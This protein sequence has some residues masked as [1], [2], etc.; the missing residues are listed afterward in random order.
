MIR[1]NKLVLLLTVLSSHWAISQHTFSPYSVYGI[2]DLQDKSMSHQFAMGDVGIAAPSYYH[3][4]SSNPALL[5][6]NLLTTFEL[7]LQG[8]SRSASSD[9]DS[10]SSGA[11]GIKYLSFAFPIIHNKWTTNLGTRPYSL[12]N[13]NFLTSSEIEN[14]PGFSGVTE[15]KGQGGITEVFWNNGVKIKDLSLGM[16]MS[17]LFGFIGEEQVI[18]ILE[19]GEAIDQIPTGTFER[20]KYRAY[21]FGFG[22]AYDISLSDKKM[23][24]LGATYDMPR[25]LTGSRI[26]R[27]ILLPS[28][29]EIEGDTLRNLS[30]DGEFQLPEEIGVGL[31]YEY[32]NKF[33][34]ALDVKYTNWVKYADY[35]S[36]SNQE[37]RKTYSIGLGM[38]VIPKYNDVDIYL[39]RVRYRLGLKYEQ[40]PY[41]LG[42]NTIE[43]YSLS[44]GWSLPVKSVSALN[45]SFRFGQRGTKVD[46]LVRERY[47]KFLLGATLSDRWFVRRKYN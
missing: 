2:G 14:N 43:D 4:N 12:V 21:N 35:G 3:I 8:E 19:D 17:M 30:I 46:G 24:H 36:G 10:Q 31:S 45:M 7:G 25:S 33:M 41:V 1:V 47:V 37:F 20:T 18:V 6:T 9:L 22:A 39:R 15:Q 34:T 27:Q 13:Y 40:L 28:G 32:K 42:N 5:T 16:R 44:L 29:G 26:V 11:A 38:E 23:I